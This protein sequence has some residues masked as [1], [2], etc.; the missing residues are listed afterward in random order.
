MRIDIS[1]LSNPGRRE[2]RAIVRFAIN[3]GAAGE[4]EGSRPRAGIAGSAVL[5]V[6]FQVWHKPQ[7]GDLSSPSQPKMCDEVGP[8]S[9][10]FCARR[11]K[12]KCGY[13]GRPSRAFRN[14]SHLWQRR[15][16]GRAVAEMQRKPL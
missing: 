16:G 12:S 5:P 13:A 6:S 10:E 1:S 15:A 7:R 3:D 9:M 8:G 2:R 11:E 4:T 14:D